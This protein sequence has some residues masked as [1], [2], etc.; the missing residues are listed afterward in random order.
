[1]KQLFTTLLAVLTFSAVQA[2]HTLNYHAWYKVLEDNPTSTKF[3]FHLNVFAECFYSNPNVARSALMLGVYNPNSGA[4]IAEVQLDYLQE[5]YLEALSDKSKA[6]CYTRVELVN[7]F[8]L[9]KDNSIDRYLFQ[10]STCCYANFFENIVATQTPGIF[11]EWEIPTGL[12]KDFQSA[13]LSTNTIY[14]LKTKTSAWLHFQESKEGFDSV[15]YAFSSALHDPNSVNY[16]PGYSSPSALNPQ[17]SAYR[18]GYTSSAPLGINLSYT[19]QDTGTLK[20]GRNFA[21]GFHQIAL[22]TSYYLNGKAYTGLRYI[23][24]HILPQLNPQFN[25]EVDSYSDSSLAIRTN[26]NNFDDFK[27]AELQRAGQRGGPF[28]FVRALT[29]TD[30]V[31]EDHAFALGDSLFYR[32]MG[33]NAIDTFYSDTLAGVIE[34]PNLDLDLNVFG[35]T[36][37]SI[38]LRWNKASYPSYIYFE[39]YRED[40]SQVGS[41]ELIY[42]GTN[43]L[44]LDVGLESGTEYTYRIY[45]LNYTL[46]NRADSLSTKTQGWKTAVHNQSESR[47]S[48][49]PNPAQQIV[50]FT[51]EISEVI[52][53]YSSS[54]KLMY[55]GIPENSLA[56]ET[57]PAGLYFIRLEGEEHRLVKT[58]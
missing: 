10:V 48:F 52:Q 47:L 31:F 1:M 23:T 21:P 49:Y 2:S 35:T 37:Q 11:Q 20:V 13:L 22:K 15:R 14:P 45:A 30:A 43:G 5:E 9:P 7:Q 54:G 57:W 19:F 51:K 39:L 28:Q 32:V 41:N 4:K 26:L 55:Q 27:K 53:V 36:E 50:Y 44:F 25:L 16:I 42:T 58:D 17:N 33:I 56:I 40:P 46:W 18:Q 24:V 12:P 38:N 8:S 29:Q 6:A 34:S 3:E